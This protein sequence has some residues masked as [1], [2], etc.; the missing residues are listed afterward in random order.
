MQQIG[1][2]VRFTPYQSYKY[3]ETAVQKGKE[4]HTDLKSS[5]LCSKLE[6]K[7]FSVTR[8]RVPNLFSKVPNT[9]AF[10]LRQQQVI[11]S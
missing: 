3:C 4:N 7:T 2:S 8:G 11:L 6:R 5:I 9:V 10:A 1:K